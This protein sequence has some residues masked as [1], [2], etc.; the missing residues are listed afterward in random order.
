MNSDSHTAKDKLEFLWKV[1]SYTN[2][3]I[4]FSDPKAGLAIALITALIATMYSSKAHLHCAPA[5]ISWATATWGDTTLGIMTTLAFG[6]LFLSAL[7]FSHSIAPRLW[8]VLFKSVRERIL[9][10][11][12]QQTPNQ[13]SP[14]PGFIYWDE[15]LRHNNA[16]E[17][18]AESMKLLPENQSEAV[19]KHLY[20]LAGV[21]S[22][23][24]YWIK[25]GFRFSYV[26]VFFAIIILF[27]S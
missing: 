5:R 26:G 14:A 24:F 10:V 11:I 15:I 25:W 3:Y 22:A 20:V 6:F 7:L 18:F 16:A 27:V 13:K 9:D 19:A 1:H 2:E 17:F 23:K 8:S 12:S 21:A 4:R